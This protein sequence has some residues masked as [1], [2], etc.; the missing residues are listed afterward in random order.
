[1]ARITSQRAVE[2]IGNRYDLVLVAS[3]RA[4]ELVNGSR[5]K[6]DDIKHSN[7]VIALKEIEQG[8]YTYKDYISRLPKKIK[9]QKDEYFTS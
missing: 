6:I 3:Q 2:A 4:R 9:G 5:P 8:K 1:M 7:T